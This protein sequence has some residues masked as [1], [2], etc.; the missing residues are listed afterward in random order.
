M[1]GRVLGPAKGAGNEMAQWI[2]KVN[3]NV[4]SRCSS[5][6]LTVDEIHSP[7]EIKKGEIFNALI[8]RRQ[9]T[10]ISPP[11]PSSKNSDDNEFEE[12]ED[13]TKGSE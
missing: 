12:F 3:G 11:R 7:T 5:R 6:P 4:I 9:G 13:K 10:S 2:L 8:E 1:L